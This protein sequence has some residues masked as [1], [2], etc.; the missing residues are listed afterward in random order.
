MVVMPTLSAEQ[1]LDGLKKA[2]QVRARRAQIRVQLKDGSLTMA[3]LLAM[4]DDDDVIAKTR[5]KYALESLPQ[6]GKITAARIMEEVGIDEVRRI[7]GL[8]V[9]QR[10]DLLKKLNK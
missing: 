1:K 5:V 9:R 6:V 7:R 10:E 4:A 3:D 2:Q 8:G